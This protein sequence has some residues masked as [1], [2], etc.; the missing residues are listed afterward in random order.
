MSTPTPD[1]PAAPPPDPLR[2]A[3]VV[4]TAVLVALV[5]AVLVLVNVVGTDAEEEPG[6]VAEISGTTPAPRADL[7]PLPVDTP[8]ITPEADLACPALM[9]QLPLE[10]AG[11]P[12]RAVDSDSPFAYAWGDPATVLVCGAEPPAGYVVGGP[13]TLL[14]SGVEWFVDTTDPDVYVWTTVDRNVPVQV[15]VPASSDSAGPTALS[16]LIGGSIPYT[17]PTPAPLPD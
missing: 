17:E 11:E 12:S 9:G 4:A 2:R 14:V 10:L 3:A 15:R 1:G 5:V 13:Q 8:P 6:P 7:P 16:P